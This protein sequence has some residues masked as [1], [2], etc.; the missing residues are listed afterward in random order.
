[1]VVVR[2]YLFE[3]LV[4][5][6][7]EYLSVS[8]NYQ[9]T[10]EGAAQVEFL[11]RT[12][13]PVV[14]F[15][16]AMQYL[17]TQFRIFAE[18]RTQEID[19][20]RGS[21]YGADGVSLFEVLQVHGVDLLPGTGVAGAAAQDEAALRG[22][23]EEVRAAQVGIKDGQPSVPV[24]QTGAVVDRPVDT[25]R[26][27]GA[28]D[29]ERFGMGQRN[30]RVDRFPFGGNG[31]VVRQEIIPR[32]VAVLLQEDGVIYREE[33]IVKSFAVGVAS[34]LACR[35]VSQG[36]KVPDVF[37]QVQRGKLLVVCRFG[38]QEGI[39]E[40]VRPFTLCP[41]RI[42][43]LECRQ[44][45]HEKGTVG[46][47]REQYGL[48]LQGFPCHRLEDLSDRDAVGSE[49]FGR[50]KIFRSVALSGAA[51]GKK[52]GRQAQKRQEECGSFHQAGRLL[53][54]DLSEALRLV[55][56]GFFRVDRRPGEVVFL[57][58]IVAAF[59]E[60]GSKFPAAL[61]EALGEAFCGDEHG[62]FPRSALAVVDQGVFGQ[63]G[64]DH[65][66]FQV[67]FAE[68]GLLAVGRLVMPQE[69]SGAA[70][71]QVVVAA[72]AGGRVEKF[73]AAVLVGRGFEGGVR[74]EDVL[75]FHVEMQQKSVL[76]PPG[77]EGYFRA[78]VELFPVDDIDV[79][80]GCVGLELGGSGG[81]V[82]QRGGQ[83][84]K[85]HVHDAF[86]DKFV[87]TQRYTMARGET[88]ENSVFSHPSLFSADVSRSEKG[89]E[90][91]FAYGKGDTFPP[92][93]G[94]GGGRGKK[95]F[96]KKC[97]FLLFYS[98]NSSNF[99]KNFRSNGIFFS[100][101]EKGQKIIIPLNT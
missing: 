9:K 11:D 45:V 7:A 48:V 94:M 75:F 47:L 24:R 95:Y 80:H 78:I 82:E 3:V 38:A 89:E 25:D 70:H 69:R 33:Y 85:D 83:L 34:G 68:G 50:G 37:H 88:N 39:G 20:I 6:V 21:L 84:D 4:R 26:L 5:K 79:L 15:D 44:A 59:V 77:L 27:F 29:A 49:Q 72:V 2:E 96:V 56:A 18:V 100:Q 93:D 46:L 67:F 99:H 19:V 61:Q 12:A 1:M 90:G 16:V 91:S 65:D 97:G 41:E 13:F 58:G 74:G 98:R 92:E 35:S 71:L 81:Q 14:H 53:Q 57:Y 8:G 64:L 30:D 40:I 17:P 87:K 52:Q 28:R 86:S 62:E 63:R 60:I 23:V 55:E 43:V 22:D 31:A 66:L 32:D 76:V 51:G 73:D 54:G 10:V 101:E 36:V 42:E